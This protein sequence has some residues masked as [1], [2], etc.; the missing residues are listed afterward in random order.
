MGLQTLTFSDRH[1]RGPAILLLVLAGGVTTA[2]AQPM[3][4]GFSPVS[5]SVGTVVGIDGRNLLNT[6]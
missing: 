1:E 6:S 4:A 5:G 2:L 3:L